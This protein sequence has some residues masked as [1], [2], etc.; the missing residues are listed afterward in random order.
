M[1]AGFPSSH[2][3]IGPETVKAYL[4]AVEGFELEA[5]ESACKEFLTG[6]LNRN[7]SFPPTAAELAQRSQLH[8]D[9]LR[10]RQAQQ[11]IGYSIG[12]LPPPGFVPLGPLEVDFGEGPIDMRNMTWA[13]KAEVL[14]T[15]RA[16]A[17]RLG[18]SVGNEDG[19][20]EAA[21]I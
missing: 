19:E 12:T 21:S 2:S 16:P 10:P 5:V 7:H 6:A 18:Y 20:G 1:L 8:D 17:K 4:S 3:S 9:I 13:E 14:R 15:K 11:E